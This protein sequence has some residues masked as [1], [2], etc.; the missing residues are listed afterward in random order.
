MGLGVEEHETFDYQL[1]TS[2]NADSS[3]SG[4]TYEVLNFAVGGYGLLQ[5]VYV[6][7]HTTPEFAPDV[8]LCFVHPNE[9][10]RM[11]DWLRT[12]L[13]DGAELDQDFSQISRLLQE[14]NASAQLPADEFRRRLSPYA[15]EILTWSLRE[16]AS[17]IRN[18]GALPVFVLLPLTNRNFEAHEVKQLTEISRNVGAL[19]IA[20][21][22]VYVS[23]EPASLGISA[24]DNHPNAQGHRLIAENIVMELKTTTL[25]GQTSQ[26]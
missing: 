5:I 15:G 18:Q 13:A 11:L 14:A 16:L 20:L 24:W 23:Y 4:K 6:A 12:A 10:G 19:P 7:K 26:R 9:V 22:E 17:A 3:L 25:L 1:E 21:T 2:L 8:V